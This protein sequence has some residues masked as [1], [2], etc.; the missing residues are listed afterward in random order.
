MSETPW[1]A[2]Q[3]LR[4]DAT[5]GQIMDRYQWLRS[6]ATPHERPPSAQLAREFAFAASA[7]GDFAITEVM[8]ERD[9]A[10]DDFD[11]AYAMVVGSDNVRDWSNLWHRED[12]LEQM[13]A[14]VAASVEAPRSGGEPSKN[15]DVVSE[16]DLGGWVDA[17]RDLVFYARVAARSNGYALGVHGTLRRDIDLLA[18][19]WTDEA[20]APEELAQAIC[21]YLASL[22][23][24]LAF[25]WVDQGDDH[26]RGED[27]P[28]GRKAWSLIAQGGF[29]R[30]YIDLSVAP[31]VPAPSVSP[32]GERWTLIDEIRNKA[33]GWAIAEHMEGQADGD[34]KA[35][36]EKAVA[37]TA[38]K[39]MAF[40]TA[41]AA[42][43][44]GQRE[45]TEPSGGAPSS[46]CECGHHGV[47]HGF[48]G[49]CRAGWCDC[50]QFTAAL[51]AGSPEGT[52]QGFPPNEELFQKMSSTI[53]RLRMQLAALSGEAGE[54]TG[55]AVIDK[56]GDVRSCWRMEEDAL[57]DAKEWAYSANGQPHKPFTVIPL[58][59][60]P[61]PLA[62][63]AGPTPKDAP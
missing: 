32:S 23:P 20:C 44:A 24:P 59:R 36:R 9:A 22:D 42:L 6:R 38:E 39:R 4:K 33:L 15:L 60:H 26:R 48:T 56:D 61:A 49:R 50:G 13:R 30:P 5:D 41:L 52:T 29:I 14:C 28:H 18:V 2:S 35:D 54:P 46:I 55:Y 3:P 45:V 53:T 17:V 7:V 57:T 16:A 19:P 10:L 63:G 25:A 31:R 21:D 47:Q 12:A 34:R 51:S 37:N 40:N 11:K 43:S 1:D 58:Y 62:P 27:K 8:T